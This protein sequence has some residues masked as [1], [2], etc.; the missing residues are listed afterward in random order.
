MSNEQGTTLNS[1]LFSWSLEEIRH[2]QLWPISIA[3]TLIIACVFALSALAERMEQVVVKQGKD[4]LTA[5]IVYSS[6]NPVPQALLNTITE[7]NSLSTSQLTR[8]ATMAFS[9]QQ[10]QLV[11]VKAVDSNYPLRGELKLSADVPSKSVTPGELWLDERVMSLLEV[12]KGDNVTI[13][14]ADFTVSGAILQEPGLSFNPFQQMPSVYIH[15][16]DIE[17]TGAL[18]LGSRVRFNL[19]LTGS[20]STLQQV[21]DSIE[22]TPSDRWIDQENASRNNDMFERTTQYLSLTVAIVII[23]AATTLVLTCQ[24]YVAGRRK[25]VAML[26]SL[27]RAQRLVATLVGYTNYNFI[28][29]RYHLWRGFGLSA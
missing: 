18:R 28:Y 12:A 4:A 19:Y 14:D 8:Y 10:M 26:K 17:K 20:E 11:T 7:Q 15:Y 27:G 25:T 6:S 23:M 16:K 22:L 3:L 5:D 21:K 24:N 9:D 13:G 2:G 29:Y 1:R